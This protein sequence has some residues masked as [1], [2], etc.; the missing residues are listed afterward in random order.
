MRATSYESRVQDG[1]LRLLGPSR[2]AT[3]KLLGSYPSRGAEQD[4]PA[5]HCDRTVEYGDN[6]RK[7][8]QP[9]EPLDP[10]RKLAGNKNWHPPSETFIRL[11]PCVDLVDRKGWC[12]QVGNRDLF[13]GHE[14]GQDDFLSATLDFVHRKVHVREHVVLGQ[15]VVGDPDLVGLPTT[16][17]AYKYLMRVNPNLLAFRT[18]PTKRAN[19]GP[20]RD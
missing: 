7:H 12:V 9:S 4:Q 3:E 15:V 20:I 1:L 10:H 13:I 14:S 19:M 16:R 11:D 5:N 2:Q 17:V 6:S 8:Q 18:C